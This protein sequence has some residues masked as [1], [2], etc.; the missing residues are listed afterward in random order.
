MYY[1]HKL[2]RKYCYIRNGKLVQ[3]N[4]FPIDQSCRYAIKIL[5]FIF[6]GIYFLCVSLLRRQTITHLAIDQA[7][8]SLTWNVGLFWVVNGMLVSRS[9]DRLELKPSF[10]FTLFETYAFFCICNQDMKHFV[11]SLAAL[12]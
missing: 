9:H 12:K 7:E 3:N 5:D 10:P 1:S 8:C 4:N 11:T 6:L 2:C